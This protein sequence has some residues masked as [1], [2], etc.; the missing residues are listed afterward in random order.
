VVTEAVADRVAE[1]EQ[2]EMREVG[3]RERRQL[4]ED[5]LVEMLPRAFTRSRVVHAYIDAADDWA[6]VDASSDKAAE[7]VIA[8]L[9]ESLGSFPVKP[10]APEVAAAERL[11]SWLLSGEA[12]SGFVLEDSCV[13]QDSEDSRSTVRCRGQDLRSQEIRNH[14]ESGKRA[15]SVGVSWKERL[16]LLLNEDLSLK[17][18]RFADEV[19]NELDTGDAEDEGATLDAQLALLSLELRGL[20]TQLCTEFAIPLSEAQEG[21]PVAGGRG[22]SQ[23]DAPASRPSAA[24]AAADDTET[25]DT[26]PWT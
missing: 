22:P 7:E 5:L 23:P 24:P 17:R 12:A 2:S 20:L 21:E 1:I 10:L 13:L 11:S 18:L 16:S 8:L 3:R 25:A 4:R 14:L 26:P 6:A 9:R 15:V 19:A